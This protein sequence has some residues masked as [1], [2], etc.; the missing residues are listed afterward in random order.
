MIKMTLTEFLLARIA[1]DEAEVR[2]HQTTWGVETWSPGCVYANTEYRS[3]TIDPARVLAECE[4]KRQ[5]VKEA[6][7]TRLAAEAFTGGSARLAV[8]YGIEVILR[9]LAAVYADHADYLAEWA[10]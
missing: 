5:I 3:M 8:T 6:K 4:A 9:A 10:L 2:E 1:E 7:A